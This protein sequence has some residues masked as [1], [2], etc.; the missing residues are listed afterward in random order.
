MRQNC[1]I[2]RKKNEAKKLSK[3]GERWEQGLQQSE[4]RYHWRLHSG[5][6]SRVSMWVTLLLEQAHGSSDLNKCNDAIPTVHR[7]VLRLSSAPQLRQF[8]FSLW[9]ILAIAFFGWKPDHLVLSK[10]LL[11]LLMLYLKHICII[12]MH[13][14]VLFTGAISQS[15]HG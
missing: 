5:N 8:W 2:K 4:D 10:K 12:W 14:A 11:L 9:P 13:L 1:W 7:N 6:N 3:W 15:L